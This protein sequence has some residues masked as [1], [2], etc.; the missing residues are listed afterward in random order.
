MSVK[1]Q[2][3][4]QNY[5]DF[6]L[7]LVLDAGKELLTINSTDDLKVEEKSSPRDL[8]TLYDKKIEKLLIEK[9]KENY[10][11]HQ[12]IGEEETADKKNYT[13][14]LTNS[15]T[16]I[17]DPIDGTNN[18]VKRMPICA[19]SIGL[20]INKEQV[21]G[22]V[23]NPYA[24]ELY[25]AIKDKGAFLNGKKIT[26]SEVTEIQRSV[27]NYEL[28]LATISTQ[29]CN[30]YMSR[31]NYIIGEISGIRS[32]GC[33]AL[34]ICYVACGRV[35]AYQADALYSWD[36][37]AATLIAREAGGYIID[38]S[39]K[40]FDLMKPNVLVA[41][42]KKLADQYLERFAKADKEN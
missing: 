14:Q 38:S 7:P 35:D 20:T 1:D 26:T 30:L 16:W 11:D 21:L 36:V 9:L 34:G 41:S 15:P 29:M 22:I 17:I 5:M 2:K 8:V 24:N 10:P 23:Y 4:L 13:P 3:E 33:A 12:F 18:F 40:P 37:A 42:N 27:I 25:T 19:I 32:Y 6:L 31:L 28:S 39:G